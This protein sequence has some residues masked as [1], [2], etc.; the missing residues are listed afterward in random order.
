M[1]ENNGVHG[2]LFCTSGS[3]FIELYYKYNTVAGNRLHLLMTFAFYYLR[4][5]LNITI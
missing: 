2:T 3:M 1:S 4:Y 5:K